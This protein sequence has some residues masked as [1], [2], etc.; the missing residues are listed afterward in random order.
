MSRRMPGEF[1]AHRETL[2]CWPA[3]EEL[4]GPYRTDGER[5]T[6]AVVEAIARSEPVRL[7]ATPT[8]AARAAQCVDSLGATAHAIELIELALNDSWARDTAPL[9]TVGAGGLTFVDFRF[10]GWGNKFQPYDH[11]DALGA[12]V[13]DLLGVACERSEMVLEGGAIAVDGVGTCVT[14]EQCLLHPSRNPQLARIDIEAE[15]SARLGVTHVV[16][17][18]LSIDDRDTDGHVDM[19]CAPAQVGT[20]LFQGCADPA[21]A[22]HERLAL[23]RAVLGRAR[24]ARGEPMDII[25]IEVLPYVDIDNQRLPAPYLNFYVANSV[26]VVPVTGH[27]YDSEALRRIG[28]AFPLRQVVAV[29]GKWLAYGGGGPHCITQQVPAC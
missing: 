19:I 11:D 15:L 5:A 9:G 29:D 21:D 20:W 22:E 3:R 26:V 8:T 13:A 25:D 7:L 6:L 16:W 27:D 17:L 23:S 4:W 12:A 14:T 1:E 18:P 2:V 10:N 24:D 28:D